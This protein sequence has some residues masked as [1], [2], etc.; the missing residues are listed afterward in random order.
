MTAVA[1]WFATARDALASVHPQ[2]PW[3][4][5]GFAIWG[6]QWA[7][8]RW[9]PAAWAYAFGW[10]PADL[11]TQQRRV[12]QALP[13]LLVGAAIPAVA[14]NGDVLHALA[15]AAIGAFAP[16]WHHALKAAPWLAYQGALGAPAPAPVED[17]AAEPP[18]QT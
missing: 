14:S 6:A 9:W 17:D 18:T 13:S 15:G 4:V 5:L 8:R 16:L 2:L 11:P 1:T 10:L 3:L 7:L 12:L